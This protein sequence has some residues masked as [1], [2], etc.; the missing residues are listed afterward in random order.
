MDHWIHVHI[1]KRREELYADAAHARIIRMLES[2][3]SSSIR[4]RIA[5]GAQ[6]ASDALAQIAQ[7]L[8]TT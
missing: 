3:R 7:R 1:Q 4:G 8:R 5:D 2:G 6:A